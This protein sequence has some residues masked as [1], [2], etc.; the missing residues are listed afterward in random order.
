MPSNNTTHFNILC[1]IYMHTLKHQIRSIKLQRYIHRITNYR[2]FLSLCAF[3]SSSHLCIYLGILCLHLHVVFFS[4][5]L[6]YQSSH[7]LFASRFCRNIS[8]IYFLFERDL[9]GYTKAINLRCAVAFTNDY[10]VR[11]RTSL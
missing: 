6:R 10:V 8:A 2:P 9:G 5:A 7:Y 3:Q 1:H 11:D 4:W